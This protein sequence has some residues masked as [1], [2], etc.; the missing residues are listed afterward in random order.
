MH[1]NVAVRHSLV[2]SGA[3][4]VLR[5]T[6]EALIALALEEAA[7]GSSRSARG[8]AAPATV[9]REPQASFSLAPGQP[10]RPATRTVVPNLVLAGDWVDTGLPA[11]IEGAVLSG[12]WAAEALPSG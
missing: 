8:P 2:S 5:E 12:R 1:P 11:T 6:N 9:V 10:S 3:D 4:S 7:S